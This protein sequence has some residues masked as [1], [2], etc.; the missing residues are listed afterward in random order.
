MLRRFLLGAGVDQATGEFRHVWVG[1]QHQRRS[2]MM[3]G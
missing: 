3:R 2:Q 1:L